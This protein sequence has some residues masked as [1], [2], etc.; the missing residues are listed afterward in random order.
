M[1][2]RDD[3]DA[4]THRVELFAT[5]VLALAAVATAWSTYQGSRWRGEQAVV[6]FAAAL[7]FAAISG[8]VHSRRQR[9]F[10]LGLGTVMLLGT[11]LWVVTLPMS[12]GR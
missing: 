8:K 4:R 12:F 11:A 5:I 1:D 6:L 10:L 2:D 9:E 7:F 3:A